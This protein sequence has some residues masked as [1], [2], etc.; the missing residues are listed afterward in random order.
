MYLFY[1]ETTYFHILAFLKP[2]MQDH[3][4]S[5]ESC[6]RSLTTYDEKIVKAEALKQIS[7]W[8]HGLEAHK[9]SPEAGQKLA[10]YLSFM[11]DKYKR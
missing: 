4:G 1:F 9:D 10:T 11:D 5:T 6:K 8:K 7:Q 2:C 3:Y